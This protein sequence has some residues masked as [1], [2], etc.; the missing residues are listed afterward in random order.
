MT[1]SLQATTASPK[2]CWNSFKHFLQSFLPTS[3]G[4][5]KVL[6]YSSIFKKQRG[7]DFGC[8][9]EYSHSFLF[10][11]YTMT[12][13]FAAMYFR[14][15]YATPDIVTRPVK[16]VNASTPTWKDFGFSPDDDGLQSIQTK[17][18]GLSASRKL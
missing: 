14:A 2:C 4:S 16:R 8:C 9:H 3:F 10:K 15:Q 17:L 13:G 7:W 18:C 6:Q 1:W 5:I 11:L 12:Y